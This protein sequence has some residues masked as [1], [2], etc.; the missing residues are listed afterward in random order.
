M[1]IG[2][3]G[4][5]GSCSAY[6]PL[7][8]TRSQRQAEDGFSDALKSAGVD[9]SQVDDLLSQIQDAVSTA[10]ESSDGSDP[11]SI[12]AA[13][14]GV[15]R[16]NGVDVAKFEDALHADRT[17]GPP[18]PPP[19]ATSGSPAS[20]LTSALEDVGLDDD[21]ISSL[22]ESLQSAVV[23]AEDDEDD[24]TDPLAVFQQT[25]EKL[26]ARERDRSGESARGL[27]RTRQS[28][29][30]RCLRIE[31]HAAGRY[32]NFADEVILFGRSKDVRRK[33]DIQIASSVA[34]KHELSRHDSASSRCG[35]RSLPR[36]APNACD[37]LRRDSA[38]IPR[39]RG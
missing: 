28:V 24:A 35:T 26:S 7:A 38:A 14:Q 22:F 13:V 12:R 31:D 2:A 39:R 16:S 10:K 25:L 33:K 5:G 15:L 29:R 37:A 23:A 8:K 4:A 34:S 19:G 18:P 17:G 30:C 11:A 21:Q 6:D 9:D 1:S 27:D 20:K 32:V 36:P 3:V